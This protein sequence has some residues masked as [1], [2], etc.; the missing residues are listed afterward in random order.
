[1]NE[2]RLY[3]TVVKPLTTEKTS[4]IGE[5][6]RQMVFR[7]AKDSTKKT[8]AQAI[9]KLFSVKVEMVRILNVKG[10]RKQFKQRE[11]V[12]SNWKKAYVSLAEGHDINLANWK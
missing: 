11:G 5:K 7:V 1:M 10:K 4:R 8:I 9:E 3:T 12:R 6:H 2:K